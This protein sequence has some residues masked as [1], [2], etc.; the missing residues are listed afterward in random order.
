M[1][2]SFLSLD[3][4]DD[5]MILLNA[6]CTDNILELERERWLFG[7]VVDHVEIY[8]SK[9]AEGLSTFIIGLVIFSCNQAAQ[10][11]VP[12]VCV[13]HLLHYIFVIISSLNFQELLPLGQVMSMLK[14]KVIVQRSRSQ[15]WKQ[16]LLQFGG[17]RVVT[18]ILIHRWL[19]N[20]AQSLKWHRRG[21]LLFF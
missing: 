7:E 11:M 15:R 2:D 5:M 19:W 1:T 9:V 16:I 21:V 10:W 6:L 17:F 13:S 20:N 8:G 4:V 18:P 3:I 14:V 12:S